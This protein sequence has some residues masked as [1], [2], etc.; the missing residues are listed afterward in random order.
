MRTATALSAPQLRVATPCRDVSSVYVQNAVRL[1][2]PNEVQE[3]RGV[4]ASATTTVATSAM[5]TNESPL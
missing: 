1:W 3:R 5:A 4:S 2:P